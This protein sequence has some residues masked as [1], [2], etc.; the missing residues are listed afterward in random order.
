MEVNEECLVAFDEFSSRNIYAPSFVAQHHLYIFVDELLFYIQQSWL[1]IAKT[2]DWAR[3]NRLKRIIFG[4]K[5]TGNLPESLPVNRGNLGEKKREPTIVK[6]RLPIAVTRDR[7]FKK[8]K[9]WGSNY[10]NFHS[11]LQI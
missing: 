4:R 2:H 11:E 6:L 5:S 3:V 1:A 7:I 10:L 9:Q 8:K